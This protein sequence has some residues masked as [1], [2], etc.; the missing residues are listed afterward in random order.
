MLVRS[1]GKLGQV[2]EQPKESRAGVQRLGKNDA[3]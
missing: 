3:Y 1:E 2:I